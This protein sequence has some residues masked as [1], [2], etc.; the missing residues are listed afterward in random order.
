LAIFRL[1]ILWLAKS[2]EVVGLG[3][4]R[5][6]AENNLATSFVI[7]SKRIE[8]M[9]KKHCINKIGHASA[10]L[11]AALLWSD[12][13]HADPAIGNCTGS[14]A[15]AIAVCTQRIESG[16]AKT[17]DRA[18]LRWYRGKIYLS[19][20]EIDKAEADFGAGIDIKDNFDNREDRA[21]IRFIKGNYDGAIADLTQGI[22]LFSSNPTL[23]MERGIVEFYAG[24]RDK[25]LQDVR[26]AA[27]RD[28][29]FY[30]P[31]Y[32]LD[33]V[34]RRYGLPGTLT[35]FENSLPPNYHEMGWW[36]PILEMLQGHATPD[37]TLAAV[38][39]RA[40]FDGNPVGITRMTCITSLYI[41][42][43]MMIQNKAADAVRAY[44]AAVGRHCTPD[45]IE[46]A[47]A[48][49]ALRQMNL[50]P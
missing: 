24:Q 7:P 8:A 25:A 11:L 10:I 19:M 1:W 23:F 46:W 28:K 9:K 21:L 27:S 31:A 43:Y 5:N 30:I 26:T 18:L 4:Q 20:G 48:R 15:P 34:S 36:P 45:N 32:W 2:S 13:A 29:T 42:E 3:F 14:G 40:H 6:M 38:I 39:T 35:A 37:Q 16:E 50:K 49:A 33:I 17:E 44:R 22:A 41:A 12:G 47:G